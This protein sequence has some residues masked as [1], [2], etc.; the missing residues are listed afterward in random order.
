MQKLINNRFFK[1]F[2]IAAILYYGLLHNKTNPESLG[3]RLS[4]EKIKS[5]IGEVSKKSANIMYEIKKAEELK[6]NNNQLKNNQ[7]QQIL[8]YTNEQ[9]NQ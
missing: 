2:G 8:N 9:Q 5:N 4:P 6:Q 1:I 7:N 3:N